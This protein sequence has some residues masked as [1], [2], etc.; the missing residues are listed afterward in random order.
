MLAAKLLLNKDSAV[1]TWRTN[2]RKPYVVE[3]LF[4]LAFEVASESDKE[5]ALSNSLKWICP[6]CA[7]C[8]TLERRVTF[9]VLCVLIVRHDACIATA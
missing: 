3:N 9:D 1:W 2:E 7:A 5:S 8:K 4:N 6:L